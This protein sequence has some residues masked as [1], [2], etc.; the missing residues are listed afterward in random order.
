MHKAVR[1]RAAYVIV[2]AV[3]E[4]VAVCFISHLLRTQSSFRIL[5]RPKFS[6]LMILH[7]NTHTHNR[8]HTISPVAHVVVLQ[9]LG[10]T[11]VSQLGDEAER[12]GGVGLEQDVVRLQR[13][14]NAR[15]REKIDSGLRWSGLRWYES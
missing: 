12:A 10:Q 15:L 6:E 13:F 8:K 9:D 3:S 7:T 4:L 11:E 5:V 14:S 2:L 1:D